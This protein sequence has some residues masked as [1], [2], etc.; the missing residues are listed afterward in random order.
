MLERFKDVAA[1]ERAREGGRGGAIQGGG[2]RDCGT[3]E[4]QPP[5]PQPQPSTPNPGTG[6]SNEASM[7]EWLTEVAAEMVALP[8]SP[9]KY[10]RCLNIARSHHGA[11]AEAD[12][13]QVSLGPHSSLTQNDRCPAPATVPTSRPMAPRSLGPHSSLTQ[14]DR[15]L[16][17]ARPRH[18]AYAEADGT[19][20]SARSL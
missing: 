10:D 8:P 3:A 2:G 16:R 19:Q 17:M 15:R 14:S 18:G 7:L 6:G 9:T 20:V 5:S 12:G 1:R 11:H 4:P 13:T